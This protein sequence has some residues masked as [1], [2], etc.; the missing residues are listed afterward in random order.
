V[1]SECDRAGTHREHAV[2][3][4]ESPPTAILAAS[5]VLAWLVAAYAQEP[6]R[7]ATGAGSSLPTELVMRESSGPP[8]S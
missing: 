1:P 7:E 8:R 5:D 2:L 3:E 4:V 6:R